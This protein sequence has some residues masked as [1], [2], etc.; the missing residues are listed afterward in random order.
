MRNILKETD[1]DLNHSLKTVECIYGWGG[2]IRT[3]GT[4]DQNPM[5]YH[6]ATPQLHIEVHYLNNIFKYFRSS[7]SVN[8]IISLFPVPNKVT[9]IKTFI[10]GF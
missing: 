3:Y 10:K 9:S 8:V 1:N 5:P 4:R 2:R 6:L 7:Y